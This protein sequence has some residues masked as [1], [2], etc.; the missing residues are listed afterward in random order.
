MEEF[1]VTKQGSHVMTNWNPRILSASRMMGV[2]FLSSASDATDHFTQS[3]RIR[4]DK[5]WPAYR[6]V[7]L[8]ESFDSAE[9][10]LTLRVKGALG[11]MRETVTKA[12][13]AELT[14]YS[15]VKGF[16]VADDAWM[17]RFASEAELN[18]AKELFTR[19]P[20]VKSLP[21]TEQNTEVPSTAVSVR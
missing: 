4:S 3:M 17:I 12:N 5:V 19:M 16:Q 6:R 15:F 20:R 2:I 14:R 18:R 13:G 10:K 1:N 8:F 21:V 7:H 11:T 9:A